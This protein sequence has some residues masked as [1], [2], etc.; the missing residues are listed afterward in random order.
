MADVLDPIDT[1][2]QAV[3]ITPGARDRDVQFERACEMYPYAKVEMDEAGT[4]VVTPGNNED[5]AYRSG[6][7]FGQLREWARRDGTGRAFD[8]TATFNLPSG[9]KRSP[10]AA[11][12]PRE[13][14][15]KEGKATRTIAKTR[16]VPTFLIEV[17]SPSDTLIQQQEKCRKWV[18]SGVSEAILLHPET[19][20]AYVF[21]AAGMITIP[22]ATKIRSAV[23]NGFE[24]DCEPIWEELV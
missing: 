13:T 12:V 9:A 22:A 7:A 23:L 17:T 5:S 8:A 1:P 14:L 20:T 10:D 19:K 4:I 6:E 21:S 2:G 18:E 3:I 16:H 11:W 15:Q 24:I